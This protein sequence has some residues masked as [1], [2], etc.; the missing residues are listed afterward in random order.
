VTLSR[1]AVDWFRAV[2]ANSDV[3]LFP[4]DGWPIRLECGS[5]Q[6]KDDGGP[7]ARMASSSLGAVNVERSLDDGER[8]FGSRHAH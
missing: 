4:Y 5:P 3:R 1:A 7:V 8:R 2:G 6:A